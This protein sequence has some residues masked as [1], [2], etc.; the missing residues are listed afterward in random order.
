MGEDSTENRLGSC[1]P[2][3]LCGP[4]QGRS[5][6]GDVIDEKQGLTVGDGRGGEAARRE[7]EP[8]GPRAAGLAPQP[9]AFEAPAQGRTDPTGD[10]G[11][12]QLGSRPGA[13]QPSPWMRWDRDD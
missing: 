9:P 11:R 4:S 5:S 12:E 13:L 7:I 2:E 10:L 8:S 1:S 6:R 3:G